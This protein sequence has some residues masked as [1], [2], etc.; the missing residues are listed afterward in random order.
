MS[1][2]MLVETLGRLSFKVSE[3]EMEENTP[4]WIFKVVGPVLEIN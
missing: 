2:I 4:V 1:L 3:T